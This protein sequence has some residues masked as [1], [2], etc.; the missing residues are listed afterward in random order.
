MAANDVRKNF[1]LFVDGRGY[2]GKVEEFNAPKLSLNTE[3]YRGGG[4]DAPIELSMG[5]EKLNSDFSLVSYDLN[6][7]ALFGVSAGSS[8]PFIVREALES[9]DGAVTAVVHTMRGK[10][11]TIDPGT[12]KP[13]DKPT[14][15]VELALNYYKLQHGSTTVHEIDIENMIRIVNGAD[16]MAQMRTA[17]GI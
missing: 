6:V 2:A 15:K 12:S 14:L 4:M 7:L 1:N 17:L 10:I 8:V 5:M 13:G 11:K 9:I 3:D 16:A